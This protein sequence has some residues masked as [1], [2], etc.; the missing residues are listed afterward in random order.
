MGFR[1]KI[2]GEAGICLTTT[3]K[4]IKRSA[5]VIAPFDSLFLFAPTMAKTDKEGYYFP[6]YSMARNDRK[7]RRLRK[8]LGVE[9]YGIF[10]MLLEILRDQ[11]DLRYP[12]MDVDLLEAEIGTSH[13]KIEAVIKGY[14]LFH[15]D[16]DFFFSPKL[17]EYL[18][19]YFKS[20]EQRSVAGQ[21]SGESRRLKALLATNDERL[22]NGR[23]TVVE[24]VEEN[25]VK[26]NKV[27]EIKRDTYSPDFES[28]WEAYKRKGAKKEAY[29]AW[30]ALT[31]DER[32]RAVQAIPA[33]FYANQE[34]KYRKDFERYLRSGKFEANHQLEPKPKFLYGDT[35]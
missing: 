13:A 8:E 15:I 16:T 27:E 24:Q 3:Q 28:A 14:E 11:P 33:Y 7:I 9:G 34:V 17:I 1:F 32:E 30:K 2:T 26:E 22:L 6:H 29:S 31:A 4:A 10:M 12:M 18:E 35:L 19:P 23:S 20:R 25:R 5:P 21:K